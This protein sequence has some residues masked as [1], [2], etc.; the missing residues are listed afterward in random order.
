MKFCEFCDL[1]IDEED[2][3]EGWHVNTCN[4]A[5]V[6]KREDDCSVWTMFKLIKLGVL[7]R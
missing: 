2:Q 7:I 4:S 5:S 6:E 3:I 1:E